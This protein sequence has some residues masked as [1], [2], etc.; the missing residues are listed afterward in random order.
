M[1]LAAVIDRD[2]VHRVILEEY[3]EGVYVLVYDAPHAQWP[4][5]DHLQ[6]DWAMAKR[7]ALQDYGIEEP[8]WRE[9]PDTR[10][11]G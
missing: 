7:A 2:D 11:N 5:E 4:C 1:A 9:V 8:M 10:F 6:D 3:P